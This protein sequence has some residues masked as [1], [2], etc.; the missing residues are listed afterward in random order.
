MPGPPFLAHLF[1][2][3]LYL[4]GRLHP[5]VLGLLTLAPELLQKVQRVILRIFD[6]Q[7]AQVPARLPHKISAFFD[8]S[9]DSWRGPPSSVKKKVAP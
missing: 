1:E 5:L 2:R 9:K 4:L 7:H 6:Q 8:G 3:A